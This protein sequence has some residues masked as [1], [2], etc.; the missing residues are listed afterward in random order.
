MKSTILKILADQQ[1]S[2]DSPEAHAFPLKERLKAK[3]ALTSVMLKAFKVIDEYE[4]L[5]V[6]ESKSGN[7]DFKSGLLEEESSGTGRFFS[8]EDLLNKEEKVKELKR[9]LKDLKEQLKSLKALLKEADL[10]IKDRIKLRVSNKKTKAMNDTSKE[11]R[12]SKIDPLIIAKILNDERQRNDENI[13]AI[14]N[15]YFGQVDIHYNSKAIDRLLDS[16]IVYCHSHSY[17]QSKDLEESISGEI[18]YLKEFITNL[19]EYYA[20]HNNQAIGLIEKEIY[21]QP[22]KL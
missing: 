7:T 2:L 15:E 10:I 5:K 12:T 3:I 6:K 20:H 4:K 17:G 22:Q 1:T 9:S 18:M 13:L 11:I 16:W 14:V 21:V 8:P 19:S